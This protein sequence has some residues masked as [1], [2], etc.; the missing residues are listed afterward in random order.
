MRRL[1][2]RIVGDHRALAQHDDAVA[3]GE[4]VGQAV[5]DEDD[6]DALRGQRADELEHVLDLAHRERRRRLVHDDELGVEGQG[7]GDRHRL[8]LAAGQQAGDLGHRFHPRAELGDHRL[9]FGAHALGVDQLEAEHV[10]RQLAA[11]EDVGG[12]VAHA[13]QREVLVDHLDARLAD[14]AAGPCR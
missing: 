5:A 2:G 1:R 7:A 9:G 3:D 6:R 13:G 11:E 14:V 10:A 12:D 4:D 8:L